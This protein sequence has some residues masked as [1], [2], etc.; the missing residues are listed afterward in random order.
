MGNEASP[1]HGCCAATT[2]VTA[3]SPPEK[4]P[5]SVDRGIQKVKQGRG[6]RHWKRPGICSRS[7]S[8]HLDR[9][10]LSLPLRRTQWRAIAAGSLCK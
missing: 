5:E 7:S 6:L 2:P 1:P 8:G 3:I 9:I 4:E 10:S